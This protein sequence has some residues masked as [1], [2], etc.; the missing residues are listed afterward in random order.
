MADKYDVVIIGAGL[1]GLA[2]AASLIRAGNRVLLLDKNHHPGGTAYV[3]SRRGFTFPMGPLGFSNPN[4]VVKV[5]E[6]L[7]IENDFSWKRVSYCLKAFNLTVPLSLPFPELTM[8]MNEQF[9]AEAD[10]ITTFFAAVEKV[11]SLLKPDG[12]QNYIS[13]I[14]ELT[15]LSVAGYLDG[16]IKD[17]RLK[18][19]LGSMGTTEPYASFPLQAAMWNLMC[20]EGIWY[21]AGGFK[22]FCDRMVNAAINMGTHSEGVYQKGTGALKLGTEVKKIL[23][24]GDSVT[25]VLLTDGTSIDSRAVISNADFKTT[26]TK[27][28]GKDDFN[29]WYQAVIEAKQSGSIL[30]VCLGVKRDQID[31]SA[32]KQASRLLY[33]R[34]A[35]NLP[36]DDKINWG[37]AHVDLYQLSGRELE[38]SLWS[39]DDKS[40]APDGSVVLIIRTEAPYSHFAGFRQGNRLRTPEYQEYKNSLGRT[41]IAEVKGLLPGIENA[42]EVID[43]ATPLTFADQGGRSEGTV[44]GWSWDYVDFHDYQ[45]RE[46][47]LS[48]IRGLYMAGYQAYSALF[49]GGVPT[50]LLSGYKAAEAALAGTGPATGVLF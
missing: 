1:G 27:L 46:L 14:G 34:T 29:P 41:I 20:Q 43:V 45:P 5:L 8:K 35:N 6:E 11:T 10:G 3:Y 12:N 19:I 13:P 36:P 50:A 24:T 47:I 17:W 37:S 33:R 15:Q 23:V 38:V 30:Q 40:L 25:G 44:A 42:I 26:F 4:L 31:L 48:P 18:R 21:P 2:A 9:P 22:K 16:L 7:G 49:L 28:L 39:N 32:F